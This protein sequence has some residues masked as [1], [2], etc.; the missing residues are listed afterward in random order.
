MDR[1]GPAAGRW[2]E[3]P[4]ERRPRRMTA[5]GFGRNR[6]RLTGEVPL[7]FLLRPAFDFPFFVPFLA[8]CVC[9]LR[10]CVCALFLLCT[11]CCNRLDFRRCFVVL[12]GA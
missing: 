5:T 2:L 3:A 7:H 10:V 1:P 8:C 4:R 12:F 6:I 9:G 11:I